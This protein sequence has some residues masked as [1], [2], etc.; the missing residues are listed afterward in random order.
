[1]LHAENNLF[2]IYSCL[3][4]RYAAWSTRRIRI[5]QLHPATRNAAARRFVAIWSTE[6]TATIG[7]KPASQPYALAVGPSGFASH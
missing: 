7:S 3:A 2:Q 1:M 4:E 5:A 6:Y